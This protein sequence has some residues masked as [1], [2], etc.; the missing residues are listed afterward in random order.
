MASSISKGETTRHYVPPDR[1]THRH[2]LVYCPL[3]LNQI[4]PLDLL[5]NLQ[6]IQEIQKRLGN[7]LNG[8]MRCNWQNSYCGKYRTTQFL[9]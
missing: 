7:I 3:N 6:K 5:V 9:A 8:S 2:I 1:I 4:K